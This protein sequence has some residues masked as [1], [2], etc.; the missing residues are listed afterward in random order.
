MQIS[1]PPD[2]YALLGLSAEVHPTRMITEAFLRR[3]SEA[4]SRMDDPTLAAGAQ[5]DLDDLHV[6]LR[7]LSSRKQQQSYLDAR[8]EGESPMRTLARMIE[9]SLEGGLLR[10]SRRQALL[11]EARRLGI[12]DFH[13]HLLMAQV[14][15]ADPS[16]LEWLRPERRSVESIRP[17]AARFAAAG[18]LALFMLLA[19]VRWLQV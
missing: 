19:M 2:Y 8:R 13:A 17:I 5:R 4:L 3:R 16:P 14:Q 9:H 15:Y 1:S 11:A 12:S 6:A 7:T 18:V 10:H